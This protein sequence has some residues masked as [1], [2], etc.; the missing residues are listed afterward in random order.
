MT[1]NA[2]SIA[3]RDQVARSTPRPSG[4]TYAAVGAFLGVVGAAIAVICASAPPGPR[5]VDAMLAPMAGLVAL[6][7]V[8]WLLMVTARNVAVMRGRIDA[9]QFVHY[10]GK[11]FDE[12]IERPARTF[13][14]LFQVP[15]LFYVAA[16]AMMSTGRIDAAQLQLAWLFVALRV[17]H[18]VVYLGWNHVP[19]RFAAWVAGCITLG[20]IWVR[21]VLP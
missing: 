21:L 5:A 20:A 7:A 3:A 6:T 9:A 11:D 1:M 2:E 16:L 19:S 14:N 8:V 12:R 4:A 17:V 10:A 13:N 15:L 18:A